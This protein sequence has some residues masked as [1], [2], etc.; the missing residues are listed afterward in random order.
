MNPDDTTLRP[1][2]AHWHQHMRCEFDRVLLAACEPGAGV[3]ARWGAVRLLDTEL[4]PILRVERDL[5]DAALDAVTRADAEQLWTLGELLEAFGD[6][7]CELGRSG[8][9]AGDFAHTAEK[10]RLALE[11]WC[12]AVE[13]SVGRLEREAVPETLVDRLDEMAGHESAV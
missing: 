3:W 12:R 9:R 11:Y 4:R 13:G 5:V 10:Y 1:M 6:R 7:L 8:Q 2:V